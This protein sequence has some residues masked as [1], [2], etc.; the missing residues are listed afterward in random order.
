MKIVKATSNHIPIIENLA[1]KIWPIA[2]KNVITQ[3]QINYMLGLFYAKEALHTQ[4]LTKKHQFYLVQN[5]MDN[6]LGFV[7]FEINCKPSKTKIHKIYV[8]PESQGLGLG[9]LLFE[10][11]KQEALKENQKAIFLNVN[12]YNKAQFFYAKLGFTI[13]EEEVIAIG[14]DYVMDDYVMEVQL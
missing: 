8:L 3:E 6:Y 1:Q 10:K 11:T 9:K 12:K 13:A 5:E 14:N 7:S 2:Y 4:M